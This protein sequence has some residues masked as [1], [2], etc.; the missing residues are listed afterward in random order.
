VD[1]EVDE[2]RH[3]DAAAASV[4]TEAH[5]GDPS[6][7]DLHVAGDEDAVDERGLDAEPHAAERYRLLRK[8]YPSGVRVLASLA[9]AALVLAPGAAAGGYAEV[10]L[11]DGRVLATGDGGSFSYPEDGS[12]VR[13]GAATVDR[14]GVTLN[15]VELLAGQVRVDQID[16]VGKQVQI[17]TVAAV[18]QVVDPRANTLVPL[19]GLGYLVVDQQ[20]RVRGHVGR[21]ALRL[22]L[23]QPAF[24]APAGAEVLVGLPVAAGAARAKR[25]DPLS[26][27]GFAGVPAA[28]LGYRPAPIV[29]VGSIGQQAVALAEQFLGVPYVWGGADPLTGFDCSGLVM[30]VYGQLG[31]H[32]THYTGSQFLE[33]MRLPRDLLAPGDLVFF[34]DDPVHGPQHEGIY[35]GG[36]RFVQAPHTGDVVKISS[37]DDP[38]YGFGYVG[39]VRPTAAP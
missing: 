16:V 35:I 15:D 24:G 13:V 14:G 22:V 6:A 28:A 31:V 9:L 18:G 25:F 12:L 23:Q 37:L 3:R 26:V 21:V 20:A 32:L 39:A 27:L 8:T 4:S 34:D 17:G 11:K 10:V 33:G 5:G 1:V 7:V 30:Y 36:G 29:G 38:R 2:A 19:G